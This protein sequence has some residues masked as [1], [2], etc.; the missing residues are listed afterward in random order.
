M[1]SKAWGPGGRTVPQDGDSTFAEELGSGPLAQPER[2]GWACDQTATWDP[3]PFPTA[4]QSCSWVMTPGNKAGDDD[5]KAAAVWRH[6]P[7]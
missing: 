5:A 2:P 6:I 1:P 3:G 7:C 4:K